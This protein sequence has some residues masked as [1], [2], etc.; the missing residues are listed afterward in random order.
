MT[1]KPSEV[2]PRFIRHLAGVVRK[3]ALKPGE[4][5]KT[6]CRQRAVA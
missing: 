5:V 2:V 4:T 3:H 1:I 6:S